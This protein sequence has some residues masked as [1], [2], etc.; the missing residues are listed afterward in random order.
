M[1]Q[2][3]ER[4]TQ[5]KLKAE[6]FGQQTVNWAEEELERTQDSA[7]SYMADLDTTVQETLEQVEDELKETEDQLQQAID[8]AQDAADDYLSSQPS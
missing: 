6:E 3:R 4:G 7:R 5:L 2:I 8:D 1:E